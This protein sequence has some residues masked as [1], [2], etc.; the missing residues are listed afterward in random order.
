MVPSA[1]ANSEAPQM[2]NGGM[3]QLRIPDS[4][5]P[6]LWNFRKELLIGIFEAIRQERIPNHRR[7]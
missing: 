5:S 7:R 2:A 6:W 4:N 3:V 1:N